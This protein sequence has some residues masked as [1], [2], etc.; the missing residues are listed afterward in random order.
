MKSFSIKVLN[1]FVCV[2]DNFLSELLIFFNLR[3]AIQFN[4]LSLKSNQET[5]SNV[6]KRLQLLST[7]VFVTIFNWSGFQPSRIKVTFPEVKNSINYYFSCFSGFFAL[8][9]PSLLRMHSRCPYTIFA[10]ELWNWGGQKQFYF[11][12]RLTFIWPLLTGLGLLKNN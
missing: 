1:S 12:G 8:Y 9:S 2:V 6:Y 4:T 3:G 7:Y 11:K 5:E 10:I